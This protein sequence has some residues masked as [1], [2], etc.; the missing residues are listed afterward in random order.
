VSGS[1]QIDLTSTSNYSSGIK[2]RLNAEG[3][4]SGSSQITLTSTQ[5]TNGLGYTPYNS[6]NPNGYISS[7]SETDTLATVT[8]RGATSSTTITLTPAA[9]DWNALRVQ[10]S[11]TTSYVN[12]AILVESFSNTVTGIGFHISGVIGK[13]LYMGTDG[14]LYWDGY[15]AYHSGNVPTWNQNTTG[16]ASNI[17]AYT[18]NQSVGTSNSP[19]FSN[20][21]ANDWY[22]NN[23][24]NEGLYNEATNNH[25]YSENS[26]RWTAA[27]T[28]ATYG[29]ISLRYGHQGTYKGSYY[30]DNS[31]IGLLNEQGGWSVRCNYG[32][33]YGGTLYGSWTVTGT[34][35]ETSSTR[36]KTNIKTIESG[37]D[38]V[39]QMRGVVYNRKDNGKE[40]IGVI[41]EEMNEIL[42]QVIQYN[43]ESEIDSVSYSRIV[44]VLIE[45]IKELKQE[46]N[47]L[48]NNG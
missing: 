14:V 5:V 18:I 41:A 29:E 32:S 12:S 46:I 16:T 28:N 42:P 37:L 2:T 26:G 45:A 21:Y 6:T 22:R 24:V 7:Y 19:T 40:E 44:G 15:V 11:Q 25:W 34:L 36:Y 27:G 8:A 13:K 20:I 48:K 31:G 35:T 4:V 17:T 10:R 39:L 1:S 33:G 3:V 9:T 30:W 38:K 47:E 43:T 23:A